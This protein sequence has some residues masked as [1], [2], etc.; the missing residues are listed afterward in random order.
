MSKEGEI[1]IVHCSRWNYREWGTIIRE[2]KAF[3]EVEVFG[4]K[5]FRMFHKKNNLEVGYTRLQKEK[6]EPIR[7]IFNK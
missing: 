1:V 6:E 4:E 2:T 5:N 3:Y 7:M